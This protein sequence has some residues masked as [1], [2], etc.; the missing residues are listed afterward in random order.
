MITSLLRVFVTVV[1]KQREH[2]EKGVIVITAILVFKL[3]IMIGRNFDRL[4]LACECESDRTC[5]ANSYDRFR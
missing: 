5:V 2:V 4:G 3:E 1:A